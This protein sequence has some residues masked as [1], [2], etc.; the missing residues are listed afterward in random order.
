MVIN[1]TH[2]RRIALLISFSTLI[3]NSS[4]QTDSSQFKTERFS[5]SLGGF[6]TSLENTVVI[7]IDQLGLGL[8]LELEDALGLEASALVVRAQGD[9]TFGKRR[10]KKLSLG[11][12]GLLRKAKRQLGRDIEIGDVVFPIK[13]EIETKFNL[14]IYKVGYNW[15][16]FKDERMRLGLGGG[17]FIMPIGFSIFTPMNESDFFQFVAPL[18]SLGVTTDFYISPKLTF[19][20]SLDIFYIQFNSFQGS[21]TDLNLKLEYQALK[22]FAIGTGIN[23]FRLN[24]ETKDDLF[25]KLDF[26]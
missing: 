8:S 2:F 25:W 24:I 26:K 14:E 3:F 7:G 9:Y 21:L 15:G 22:H 17:L 18:P 10:N 13:T 23:T 19:S 12:I 1:L 16:F 5:F 4:A 6:Y 11:Y 20:Q